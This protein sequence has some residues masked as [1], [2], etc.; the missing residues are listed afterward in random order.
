MIR[1]RGN[2]YAH[3]VLRGGN[4]PNYDSQNIRLCEQELAANH[5]PGNI[6][7][8]C[9]HANSNKDFSMQP[10]VMEN[11]INQVVEGNSS[12]VGI[13]IESNLHEGAQKIPKDLSQLKYGVSVTDGCP[14]C[15]GAPGFTVTG[16]P[17]V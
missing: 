9:S 3:V 2:R 15:A 4:T 5:L 1:T 14:G 13:M 11:V 10:L 7:V 6:M 12:I 16:A 8:D 17:G